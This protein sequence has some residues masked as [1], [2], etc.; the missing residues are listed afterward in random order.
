MTPARKRAV[1]IGGAVIVAGALAF[2][3]WRAFS[4]PPPEVH[5]LE[6]AQKQGERAQSASARITENLNEIAENLKKGAELGSQSHKINALTEAQQ[7]SL[8]GLVGL[9]KR[10][11][12][13]VSKTTSSLAGTKQSAAEVARISRAQAD[14]I[15]RAVA[16]LRRLRD[17][18]ATAGDAS[19][20]LTRL[21]V[22]GAR[23][24]H[25]SQKDFSRR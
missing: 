16:S 17:Y 22:Y 4:N 2:V 1:F 24:A 13:S 5:Q 23:L 21:A 19:A 11:L 6:R 25:Q 12:S 14:V 18:A 20:K 9:L 15:N 7:R 8:A 3:G 10:Q